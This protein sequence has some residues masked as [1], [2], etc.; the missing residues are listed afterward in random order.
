[1]KRILSLLIC[2]ALL[3]SA[4]PVALAEASDA[5]NKTATNPFTEIEEGELA[6]KYGVGLMCNE[7]GTYAGGCG[8]GV[9]IKKNYD[10]DIIEML[11][12]HGIAWC[13]GDLAFISL[14]HPQ[15]IEMGEL[16]ENTEFVEA[17]Y[18]LEDGRR[19]TIIYS[20]EMMD[21]Y[22]ELALVDADPNTIDP[23]LKN[24]AS[25]PFSG[26]YYA[27]L[28]KG[29]KSDAVKALQE[30]LISGGYLNDKADGIFGKKIQAAVEEFQKENGFEATGVATNAVQQ[31]LFNP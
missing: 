6:H 21:V 15:Q 12:E 10:T 5:A 24:N 3:I 16:W 9:S 30:A 20:P 2:I 1:M 31:L 18:E 28:E 26:S 19:T 13:M 4:V 22:K 23:L 7:V 25:A 11:E 27:A 8:W 14:I 17:P 29:D